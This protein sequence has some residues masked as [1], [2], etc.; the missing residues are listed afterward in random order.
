MLRKVH[1]KHL[2]EGNKQGACLPN[3]EVMKFSKNTRDRSN[4]LVSAP[5]S[6]ADE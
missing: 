4:T 1:E 3:V 6:T 2:H 5:V